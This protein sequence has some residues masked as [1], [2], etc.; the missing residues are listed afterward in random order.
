MGTRLVAIKDMQDGFWEI[1][2]SLSLSLSLAL[3]QI[4]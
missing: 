3:P 2:V 4:V 1:E